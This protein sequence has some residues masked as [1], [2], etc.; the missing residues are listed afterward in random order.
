MI[1]GGKSK[2]SANPTK[3]FFV[4]MIRVQELGFDLL[5]HQIRSFQIY[6]KY[7]PNFAEIVS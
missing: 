3:A 4:R 5:E 2:A 7:L 1:P 6:Y